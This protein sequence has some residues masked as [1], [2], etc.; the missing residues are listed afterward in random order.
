MKSISAARNARGLTG[1]VTFVYP[2]GGFLLWFDTQGK[3][4]RVA[5]RY[6]P[7]GI[8]VEAGDEI[9]CALE[10]GE[11]ICHLDGLAGAGGA[12]IEL[13]GQSVPK[14]GMAY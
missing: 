11:L 12:R 6:V 8:Q 7:A 14:Q 13:P 1:Q 4:V 2:D 3:A 10:D 9:P 5:A